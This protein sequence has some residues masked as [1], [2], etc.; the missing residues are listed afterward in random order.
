MIK[1]TINPTIIDQPNNQSAEVMTSEGAETQQYML[2]EE[3]AKDIADLVKDP[4]RE[5]KKQ[6]LAILLQCS[7]SP[8]NRTL[9]VETDIVHTLLKNLGDEVITHMPPPSP[10]N[11]PLRA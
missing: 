7:D 8:D 1:V 9:F 6:A 10:I 5:V 11:N 4:K 3:V 2:S